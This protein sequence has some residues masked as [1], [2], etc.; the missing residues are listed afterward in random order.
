MSAAPS[1]SS[2]LLE[3]SLSI[4]TLARNI[5]EFGIHKVICAA[6]E[7]IRDDNAHPPKENHSPHT[8]G[9]AIFTSTQKLELV[10]QI[11]VALDA[12][13]RNNRDPGN[14]LLAQLAR[15]FTYLDNRTLDGV[16]V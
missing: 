15:Q 11:A 7:V 2:P 13:A 6:C 12:A 3:R 9:F 14:E 10:T 16:Q 5:V 1:S 8:N 4:T